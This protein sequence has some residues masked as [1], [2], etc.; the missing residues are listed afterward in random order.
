MSCARLL[1]CVSRS[2]AVVS[3]TGSGGGRHSVSETG[4]LPPAAVCSRPCPPCCC[5]LFFFF[6]LDGSC[7]SGARVRL[8]CIC[9]GPYGIG[10]TPDPICDDSPTAAQNAGTNTTRRK[11]GARILISGDFEEEPRLAA[12]FPPGWQ[13]LASFSP[14]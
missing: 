11:F 4:S 12:F 13:R 14:N 6:F 3:G 7:F 1:I 8:W 5:L 9:S 10:S 2:V